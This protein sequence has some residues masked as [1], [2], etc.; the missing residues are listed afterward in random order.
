MKKS[1][2]TLTTGLEPVR[3]INPNYRSLTGAI[4]SLKNNRLNRFESSLERDFARIIEF[5]SAVKDYVEQPVEIEFLHEG[6][7]V[8]YV[9]DFLVNYKHSIVSGVWIKPMLVE[10]KYRS[11]LK[12]KWNEYKPK[13]SAAI[14]FA[15]TRGWR[16][17][18]MTEVEI[19]TEFLQN[20]IFLQHYKKAMVNVDDRAVILREVE[21]LGLTTPNELL[22]N[23]TSNTQ[24]RASLLYCLWHI[25]SNAEIGVDLDKKIKMNSA[26]WDNSSNSK[27]LVL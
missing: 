13:F 1:E 23:L 5:D 16:F 15:R 2:Q 9:P 8:K 11:D 20:A 17:K 14:N 26:I 6:K 18:I 21:K 25:V 22:A 19:R 12:V 24:R 4:P 7:Q 10:V 3:E 27:N